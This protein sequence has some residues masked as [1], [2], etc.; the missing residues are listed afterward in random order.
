M[1]MDV[2]RE[3]REPLTNKLLFRFDPERDLVEVRRRGVPVII[4]LAEYRQLSEET[5]DNTTERKV[6][7]A[8]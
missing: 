4:D 6:I 5:L 2:F 8:Y 7:S 3:I 1:R